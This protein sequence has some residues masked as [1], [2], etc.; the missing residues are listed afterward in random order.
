MYYSPC[1][2]K[3]CPCIVMPGQFFSALVYIMYPTE[4]SVSRPPSHLA[5]SKNVV[6]RPHKRVG[7]RQ[8]QTNSR[9]SLGLQFHRAPT[10]NDRGGYVGQWDA[11]GLLGPALGPFDSRASWRRRDSDGAVL[12]TTEFSLRPRAPKPRFCRLFYK[13]NCRG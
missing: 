5:C 6:F 4:L 11:A 12:V 1:A 7:A 2:R 10:D 13:V 3:G 8:Q 9:R